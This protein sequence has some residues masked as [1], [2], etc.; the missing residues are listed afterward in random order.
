MS[1]TKSSIKPNAVRVFVF[2]L[3]TVALA[4]CSTA[5]KISIRQEQQ[6]QIQETIIEQQG[7]IENMSL[8]LYLL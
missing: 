5:Q 6:G 8:S 1:S 4:A 7:R 2:C 3:A